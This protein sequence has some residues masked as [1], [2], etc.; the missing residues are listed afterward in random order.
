MH[1]ASIRQITLI[2]WTFIAGIWLLMI[3]GY[4]LEKLS[5]S[6]NLARYGTSL[7]MDSAI[8]TRDE[9]DMPDCVHDGMSCILGVHGLNIAGS[10]MNQRNKLFEKYTIF[11]TDQ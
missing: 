7:L 10:V 9:E 2:S 1:A 3:S 4:R 5:S 8:M 11:F 6:P